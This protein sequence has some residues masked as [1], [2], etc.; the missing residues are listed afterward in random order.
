[1]WFIMKKCC[2][3][4]RFVKFINCPACIQ[5]EDPLLGK[6][7]PIALSKNVGEEGQKYIQDPCYQCD[8]C[9]RWFIIVEIKKGDSPY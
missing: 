1:M 3:E 5:E 6:L 8:T 4:E 9:G 2:K 7:E